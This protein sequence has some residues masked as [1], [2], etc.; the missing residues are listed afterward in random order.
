MNNILITQFRQ[1]MRRDVLLALASCACAALVGGCESL[2]GCPRNPVDVGDELERLTPYFTQ[3][4][5]SSYYLDGKSAPKSPPDKSVS[6]KPAKKAAP[7]L[8]NPALRRPG[9]DQKDYRDRV[10]C[11]RMRVID[12][13]FTDYEQQLYKLH[14]IGT[15]AG[16]F[17]VLGLTAAGSVAGSAETKAILSAIAAG[18]TGAKLSVDKNLY[19]QQTMPIIF[20]HME[21][22][23]KTQRQMIFANLKKSAS[24]YPLPQAMSDVDFY[25]KLGTLPAA[26]VDISKTVGNATNFVGQAAVTAP[27]ALLSATPTTVS[28]T[29]A[30]EFRDISSG[31]PA[32]I[33]GR[34]LKFGD[35]QQQDITDSV[36]LGTNKFPHQYNTTS[37][38]TAEA[39]LI[40]SGP[41][42]VNTNTV[43]ITVTNQ[44]NAATAPAPA[45]SP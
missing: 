2:Q 8:P 20:Q 9:E 18:V 7:E 4:V 45:A 41:L 23:R 28:G 38:Y 27:V 10:V 34:L 21:N 12:L 44:T 35:G 16:D 19:Y 26:I 22:L 43:S 31:L 3:D 5:V 1:L 36:K 11:C 29:N 40:I 25:Y 39:A 24:D 14:N 30:V 17:A 15:I 32:L 6:K 33:T 37:N 13:L 42:G